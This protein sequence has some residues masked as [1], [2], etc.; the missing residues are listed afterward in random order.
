MLKSPTELLWEKRLRQAIVAQAHSLD[1]R[2]WDYAQA[3]IRAAAQEL[4]AL[5]G[6]AVPVVVQLVEAE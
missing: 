2:E 4:E 1:D 5:R 6:P 3:F